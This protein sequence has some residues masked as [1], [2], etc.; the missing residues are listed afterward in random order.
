MKLIRI[1]SCAVALLILLW[2]SKGFSQDKESKIP[3]NIT[4]THA[5][6]EIMSAAGTCTLI[7]LDQEG[8]P[9][10]RVMDAFLPEDDFTVWLGTN[11]K[12]RKVTQIKNDPRVTLFYLDQD[13]SGYVMIHGQAQIVDDPIE[14]QERWKEEWE[15]F[16]QNKEEAYLLIKVTPEWMEVISNTRNIVGDPLSWEPQ[17]VL[18]D[19]THK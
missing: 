12:S 16:Y 18:F 6:R 14:K 2:P 8:R 10:A 3:L 17:K 5:A 13:A 15:A 1:C 9:R 7:T 4:I 11:S 19:G